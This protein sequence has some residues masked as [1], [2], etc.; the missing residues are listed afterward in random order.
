MIKKLDTNRLLEKRVAKLEK[1]LQMK[2]EADVNAMARIYLFEAIK[3]NGISNQELLEECLKSL[4]D[5]QLAKIANECVYLMNYNQVD[6][7]CNGLA[8]PSFSK[9]HNAFYL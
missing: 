9:A 1:Q 2:N 5:E 3:E 6:N 8:I 7:V 4:N